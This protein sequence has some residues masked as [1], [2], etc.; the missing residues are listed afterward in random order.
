ML[1]PV[2]EPVLPDD[3][4]VSDGERT[5]VQERL[6]RAHDLGQVDLV[7]FDERVRAVWAA[8]TRA[9]LRRVTAD[10]PEVPPAPGVFAATGP[11]T[12]MRVLAIIWT[13]LS[14]VALTAWGILALT[15]DLDYPWFLWVALPPGAVLAV[16]YAVGIGR[17]P[18][19]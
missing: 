2:T 19:S 14:V 7:E 5:Q 1:P 16:L 10:L 9:E 13:C 8:R 12:A 17:P 11:G 3:A 18:R 4:R 15:T 6:R